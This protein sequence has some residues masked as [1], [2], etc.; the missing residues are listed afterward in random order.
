M[1]NF[2][3]ATMMCLAVTLPAQANDTNFYTP[4]VNAYMHYNFGAASA[5]SLGLHYG[6]RMDY[7]DSFQAAA[8]H[9]MPSLM[10][11]DFSADS[12]FSGASLNGITFAKRSLRLNQ[13]GEE[14]ATTS[15]TAFDWGLLA[16]GVAGVGFGIYQVSRK[17]ESPDPSSKP[18]NTGT[19]PGNGNCVP[20]TVPLIGG[21]CAPTTAP[22]A[23]GACAPG[24][25]P[26]V[27]GQ[28]AP[29]P[30]TGTTPPGA[31][32]ACAP[33]T[34]PVIGGQCAPTTPQGAGGTCAP[35]TVPI[36]GGQCAPTGYSSSAFERRFF[37]ENIDVKHNEWLDSDYGHMGDLYAQ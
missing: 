12:G 36:I 34:V 17:D 16:V 3:L 19:A 29:N 28:C 20:G 27:G 35:G 7:N 13:S 18:S 33:G 26:V 32:G 6:F 37:I 14:G 23:G 31:G 9:A 11:L 15:F 1:R 21:Q 22:G 8:G 30:T 2:M 25:V 10:Q 5:H 24:T 4:K